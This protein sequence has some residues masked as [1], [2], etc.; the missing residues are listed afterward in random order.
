MQFTYFCDNCNFPPDAAKQK[1]STDFP[2]A[3][4]RFLTCENVGCLQK[5]T[6]FTKDVRG[7]GNF[8]RETISARKYS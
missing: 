3:R 1:V 4:D 2:R 8:S 5:I 7:A 6:G